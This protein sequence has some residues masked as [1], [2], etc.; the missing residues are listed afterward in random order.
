MIESGYT[1]SGAPN[2]RLG[3]GVNVDDVQPYP[4]AFPF[5]SPAF[6]GRDR[7]HIDPGEVGGGPV[8]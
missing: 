2:N 7:R 6:S 1:Q 3:D 4:Q 5:L 8:N